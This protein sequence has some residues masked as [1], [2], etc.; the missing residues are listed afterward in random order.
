MPDK[1]VGE[2]ERF[3]AENA[4]S[5]RD[6]GIL[7]ISLDT[8]LDPIDTADGTL[9]TDNFKAGEL[10]GQWAAATLGDAAADAKIAMLDLN[11]NQ[12]SVDVQR[13]G[14]SGAL[15]VMENGARSVRNVRGA[16]CE[17]VVDALHAPIERLRHAFETFGRIA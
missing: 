10:I 4:V 17:E 6:N 11:A 14:A 3:L 8:P 16:S 12:V 7:V 2:T 15:E 1:F 5:A 9:A 13:E